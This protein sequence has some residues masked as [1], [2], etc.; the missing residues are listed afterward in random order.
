MHGDERPLELAQSWASVAIGW[1]HRISVTSQEIDRPFSYPSRTQDHMGTRRDHPILTALGLLVLVAALV[2]VA[3]GALLTFAFEHVLR[4]HL[5]LTQRWTWAIAV[6]VVA[7]CA[8]SLRSR[9]GSGGAGRYMLLALVAS[10]VVLVARFGTHARWAVEML[11][12]YAP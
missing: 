4:L 8:M 3:P 7:A 10:A 6:S 2:L 9:R 1:S 5:D 11:R 12:E